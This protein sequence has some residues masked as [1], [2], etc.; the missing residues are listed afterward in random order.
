MKT[1]YFLIPV[2]ILTSCKEKQNEAVEPVV[3][4]EPRTTVALEDT[5]DQDQA[6]QS[7]K[8]EKLY[9]MPD[10]SEQLAELVLEK[11]FFK[12]TDEFVLDFHY[13][14]LNEDYTSNYQSF[15]Q[16]ISE[17]IDIM[18][19]QA[20]ILEDKAIYCDTIGVD[21]LQ[22]ERT[23]RYK[24]YSRTDQLLSVVFYKENYYAGALHPTYLFDCFNYDLQL[25]NFKTYADVF[26]ETSQDEVL[27]IL[28]TKLKQGTEG[29]DCWEMTLEDF[30]PYR[31]NFVFGEKMI[32]FYFDDCVIC[33]SYTGTF[34]IEVSLDQLMPYM[35]QYKQPAEVGI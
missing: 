6:I 24:V 23:I 18:G 13:P 27:A 29:G 2:L 19:T 30:A 28:N 4:V 8:K 32:K 25:F 33:P 15:N 12:E 1:C 34:S 26:T 22:E 5:L 11:E 14:W 20:Q 16:R 31:D 9:R 21:R 3:E 35:K 7:L 17:Y 10:D